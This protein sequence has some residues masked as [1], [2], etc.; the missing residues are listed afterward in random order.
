[1]EHWRNDYVLKSY[2]A[3]W[4]YTVIYWPRLPLFQHKVVIYI[5]SK[6][7][8]FWQI[9]INSKLVPKRSKRVPRLHFTVVWGSVK[10]SVAVPSS[11][12]WRPFF[13]GELWE[14]VLQREGL[15]VGLNRCQL[16]PL[17]EG[18]I[19][20]WGVCVCAHVWVSC[21]C[22]CVKVSLSVCKN[23]GGKP[24]RKSHIVHVR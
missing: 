20:L 1:M 10:C 12:S 5:I 8:E 21:K 15:V 6:S 22:L 9:K 7:S 4:R 18:D 13:W 11:V 16:K 14:E 23:G 19:T 24:G 17:C 2:T 3:I